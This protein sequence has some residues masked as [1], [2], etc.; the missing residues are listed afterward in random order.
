MNLDLDFDDNTQ[1][2]DQTDDALATIGNAHEDVCVNTPLVSI[3]FH[4]YQ[5]NDN[6]IDGTNGLL[7]R[8]V[9]NALADQHCQAIARH[10]HD[11]QVTVQGREAITSDQAVMPSKMFDA[12][13]TLLPDFSAVRTEAQNVR[14]QTLYASLVAHRES[15]I[16]L[17]EGH[18]EVLPDHPLQ[19]AFVSNTR[20][21]S[22]YAAGA[23]FDAK[24][25]IRY[26]L[27][28]NPNRLALLETARRIAQGRS[29]SKVGNNVSEEELLAI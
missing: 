21:S 11:I 17:I 9:F 3:S 8:N 15:L 13:G 1:T 7:I 20:A 10:I 27:D 5:V 4:R 14:A 23:V 26:R 6:I 19:F 28:T 29:M 18:N 24:I 25:A 2:A 22:S 16:A 12:T